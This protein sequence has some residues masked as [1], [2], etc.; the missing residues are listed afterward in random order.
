LTSISIPSGVTSIGYAAFFGASSL[1]SITFSEPSKLTSIGI[2][3]FYGALSLT[4][5]TIPSGVTSIGMSAFS[6][7]SSLTSITFSESSKLTSIGDYAFDGAAKLSSVRFLGNAPASIGAHVFTGVSGTVYHFAGATGF[8]PF[9]DLFHGLPQAYFLLPPAALVATA[10][11]ASVTISVATPPS[12][13]PPPSSYTISAV[14]DATK[15]CV[16]DGPTGSCT[17]SG[18]TS[19]TPYTFTAIAY[20]TTPAVTSIVSDPSNQV[21]PTEP[22]PPAVPLPLDAAPIPVAVAPIPPATPTRIIWSQSSRIVNQPITARFTTSLEVTYTITA[23][24]TTNRRFQTRTT[25]TAR[26]TCT[27]K[28]NKKTTKRTATCT[29]RLKQAGTWIIAITPTQN[30][31]VG[32]PAT[33]TI[34]ANTP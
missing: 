20:T 11:A 7:A 22:I 6:G 2:L 10:G 32:T 28:T 4:S 29:I 15:T 23:T 25:R 9:S 27:I 33:K 16:I 30:G 3:A 13:G 8:D 18:L 19:G 5:I 24:S 12:P 14:S 1:T 17:I 21:T 34:K 31:I 26:G